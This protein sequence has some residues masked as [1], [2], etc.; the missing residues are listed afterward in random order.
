MFGI[1]FYTYGCIIIASTVC[2]A[3][4]SYYLIK[5]RVRKL[6]SDFLFYLA[7]I[8]IIGARIFYFMLNFNRFDD[9]WQLL[10][11]WQDGLVMYGGIIFGVIYILHYCNKKGFDFLYLI[12]NLMP[13]LYLGLIAAGSMMYMSGSGGPGYWMTIYWSIFLWVSL[14]LRFILKGKWFSTGYIFLGGIFYYSL[15]QAALSFINSLEDSYF[16]FSL[17]MII[18]FLVA[19]IA[20]GVVF[21]SQKKYRSDWFIWYKKVNFKMIEAYNFAKQKWPRK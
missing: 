3:L 2:G 17:H 4:L 12:D 5:E 10:Y 15:G 6:S 9:F 14:I 8:S 19:L 20:F 18:S 11:F 1:Y 21:R 16:T 13:G 7:I